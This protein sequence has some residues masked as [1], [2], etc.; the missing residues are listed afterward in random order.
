MI[1]CSSKLLLIKCGVPLT[2]MSIVFTD[3][4]APLKKVEI[5]IV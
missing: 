4:K 2:W 5:K 1:L 3:C